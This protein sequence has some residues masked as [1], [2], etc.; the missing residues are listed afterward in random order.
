MHKPVEIALHGL[1]W[2]AALERDI[3]AG[4]D[5]LERIS[6]RIRRCRLDAEMLPSE[7]QMPAR[8]AVRL[9]VSLPGTE[10]VVHREH[11]TDACAAV[12]DAFAAVGVQLNEMM[13]RTAA[14]AP[15]GQRDK[16]VD[17]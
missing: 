12:R 3:A 11:G 17:A 6:D 8:C 10:V 4:A 15:A 16:G 14:P 5:Q 13:S 9:T 7:P 1:V 2:S